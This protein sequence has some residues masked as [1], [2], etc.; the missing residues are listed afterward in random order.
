ILCGLA[1]RGEFKEAVDRGLIP[2]LY[3][4]EAIAK[5]SSAA[6]RIGRQASFQLK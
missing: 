5:L 6:Q 1:G 3:D 2:V 4:L